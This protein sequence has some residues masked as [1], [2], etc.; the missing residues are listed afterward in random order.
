MKKWA[1]ERKQHR[2]G[3][4]SI[5]STGWSGTGWKGDFRRQESVPRLEERQ[6]K[7]VIPDHGGIEWWAQEVGLDP[8][9]GW[10]PL[11]I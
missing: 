10:N 7:W 11:N 2:E 1:E 6:E 5:S 3:C 9:S 4:G 8:E